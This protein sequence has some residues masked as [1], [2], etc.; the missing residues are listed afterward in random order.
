MKEVKGYP[1]GLFCW[2]DLMTSDVQAAKVFYHGLFGWEFDD[3]PTDIG[4][5]YSMCQSE[6]KNVAGIS[7]LSPDMQ[8]QGVPPVWNSYIKHDHA[9]QIAVSME[10]AGGTLIMPPMDVMESGRM[11]MASDPSGAVFGVWQPNQHIGA[12]LV[13][14]PNTLIWNEL[15]TRQTEVAKKF[16]TT[17]FGWDAATDESGYVTFKTDD[18]AH[19]GMMQIQDA[20]GDV[21]PNWSIY[22]MVADLQ[23]S[24]DKVPQLGGKIE[25][26]PTS[27][28]EM[29]KF[30]VIQ[31]PQGA[32]FT[33]MQFDGPVDDPPGID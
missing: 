2:V 5:V 7:P 19:S 11:C 1:D 24:V 8:S 22:F 16:Y 25:V 9:D 3:V 26:P 23:E 32:I 27:A 13:N 10:E 12:Q 6:G 21:P 31:D 29:G 33:I 17:V 20:W 18:R 14:R 28:G 4:P 30:S 15:Q